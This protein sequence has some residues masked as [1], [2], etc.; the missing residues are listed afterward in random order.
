[1]RRLKL[2]PL[3][4]LAALVAVQALQAQDSP[5]PSTA[6]SRVPQVPGLFRILRGFNA[7][8]TIAGLH[9]SQT[10]YATLVQPALGYSIDRRFSLDATIP[11]YLYR[12]DETHDLTVPTY[13]HLLPQ[14]GELGDLIFGVHAQ[15]VPRDF[16]YQFTFSITAPTGD[17]VHG[18]STGRPTFDVSNRVQ[19]SFRRASPFLELGIGDSSNLAN[20]QLTRNFNSLGPLAHFQ[21]GIAVPLVYR[22]TFAANAYEQL[23][24]GDQKLYQTVP[25]HDAPN[26]TVVTGRSLSEDNGFTNTL[27]IPFGTHTTV[28]GYYNRSLRFRDDTVS[29]GITFLLRGAP[30][31]SDDELLQQIELELKNLPPRTAP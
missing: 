23:P 24:I 25:L 28:S 3:L 11:V 30:V 4:L 6:T 15:F 20:Q 22:A 10:G 18:L 29:F 27:D 1:M 17:V 19:R 16:A 5:T 7:G 12:L 14:H 2:L 9:E 31:V 13:I 26:V 8:I 21:A